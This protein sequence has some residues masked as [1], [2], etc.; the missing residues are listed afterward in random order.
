M[1]RL[2]HARGMAAAVLL[3]AM[4][5]LP[6]EREFELSGRIL[7]EAQ[8][9]VAVHGAT[10]PFSTSTLTDASG[11]FRFKL[12]PGSYTVA[13]FAPGYGESRMTVDVG[14]ASA[15][16]KG[17]VEIVLR[18]E[19]AAAPDRHH[20]VSA[21]E[22]SIPDKARKEY[23]NAQKRLA[24]RDIAGAVARLQRAVEIAP[25]FS[26]AWNNLG[27]IAYQTQN[28]SLAEQNFRR[29]LAEDPEAYAPLV[30]LGGV[31]LNLNK[32]D[33]ALKYN[34]HAVL[35]RPADALAN[36]QLGMTYLARGRLEPAEKFLR[37]AV[38]LDPAH[39]SHP[40]LLLAEIYARRNDRIAA[41]AQLE[42]FLEHHPDWPSAAQMRKGIEKLRQPQ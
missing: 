5:L 33:E 13:A 28:Y 39:F 14:P 12:A 10:T 9:S 40:Q 27:T 36:S 38:R 41:A 3:A 8:A 1:V 16:E 11:R 7:P 6:A 20:M 18:L 15:G 42:D 31:L 30:N 19:D 32:L 22:L 29:A 25:Q 23:D 35:K 21:R 37:E 24:T 34:L 26:A 17:R 4:T 2:A